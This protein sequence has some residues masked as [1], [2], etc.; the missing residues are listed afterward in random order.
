MLSNM[1]LGIYIFFFERRS[2][3]E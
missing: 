3:C 2:T 1:V